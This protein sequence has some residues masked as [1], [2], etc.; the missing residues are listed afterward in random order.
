ME[1]STSLLKSGGAQPCTS[2]CNEY[3]A[4][5]SL[6]L[7]YWE[8]RTTRKATSCRA[9]VGNALLFVGSH[10]QSLL[11]SSL[12][13]AVAA[14]LLKCVGF[15][16]SPLSLASAIASCCVVL[17]HIVVQPIAFGSGWTVCVALVLLFLVGTQKLLAALAAGSLPQGFFRFVGNSYLY[18]L[19]PLMLAALLA[20]IL[21]L[22][23]FLRILLAVCRGGYHL[24]CP[25]NPALHSL[26]A[27]ANDAVMGRP[28]S[29]SP[30]DPL[31]Q[32]SPALLSELVASELSP[33]RLGVAMT[34]QRRTLAPPVTALSGTAVK[35]EAPG[36]E[37]SASPRQESASAKG[38]WLVALWIRGPFLLAALGCFC[39]GLSLLLFALAA[40]SGSPPVSS[41]GQ[42]AF[43]SLSHLL[44]PSQQP[45]LQHAEVDSLTA[46][47]PQPP[48][49][50][51]LARKLLHHQQ[52]EGGAVM[53]QESRQHW[54]PNQEAHL[55][56]V[57]Q[58]TEAPIVGAA[59]NVGFHSETDA[60]L[61]VGDSFLQARSQEP[62]S[63]R[64]QQ[65]RQKS[66]AALLLLALGLLIPLLGN[67][68]GEWVEGEL[69][70]SR[71]RSRLQRSYMSEPLQK[72]PPS[73][74]LCV[75]DMFFA[76]MVMIKRNPWMLVPPPVLVIHS[77]KKTGPA[78]SS[79]ATTPRAQFSGPLV[80]MTQERIAHQGSQSFLGIGTQPAKEEDK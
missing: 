67:S 41:R 23:H 72:V 31:S 64:D 42:G 36:E 20:G 76:H 3:D 30:R 13:C 48:T 46:E 43:E 27:L 32:A 78:D 70:T 8:L 61:K 1:D 62:Q 35:A 79:G 52:T 71:K 12:A 18:W 63:S 14:A 7:K 44:L 65:Q 69:S 16:M 5:H 4:L 15:R 56:G 51:P 10:L 49:G 55:S 80:H 58:A 19:A 2:A 38:A 50:A 11:Y 34:Q 39:V 45:L 60:A 66:A 24:F 57:L 21:L 47:K 68:L 59:R 28:L 9:R 26:D 54:K 29:V 53:L 25:P 17:V 6:E 40:D 73:C 37:P 77:I 33:R 75:S 74:T 22:W